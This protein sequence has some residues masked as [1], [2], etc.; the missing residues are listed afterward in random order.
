MGQWRFGAS[1]SHRRAGRFVRA[2]PEVPTAIYARGGAADRA[3]KAAHCGGGGAH[4]AHAQ[5]ETLHMRIRPALCSDLPAIGSG[6]PE[7]RHRD[8]QV[9]HQTQR[10][11][12]DLREN[13]FITS[14]PGIHAAHGALPDP[15][16][17]VCP[18]GAVR[19]NGVVV[20]SRPAHPGLH[21]HRH[22]PLRSRGA[23]HPTGGAVFD[24]A[25]GRHLRPHRR[26]QRGDD[27][28]PSPEQSPQ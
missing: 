8:G 18:A 3:R 20:E 6:R 22:L 4:H 16:A 14:A 19:T 17:A 7:V 10:R 26:Q 1:A 15:V 28:L 9:G 12:R 2:L 24:H 13:I 27:Q 25:S 23:F 11:A 21:P 5:E